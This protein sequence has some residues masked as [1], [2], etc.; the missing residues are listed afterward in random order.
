MSKIET[1][2][3]GCLAGMVLTM[4]IF[5]TH[6]A[7]RTQPRLNALR[8][9]LASAYSENRYDKAWTSYREA[10]AEADQLKAAALKASDEYIPHLPP[11]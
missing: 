2:M 7:L 11:E 9:E 5:F 4:A 8:A 1:F 10:Q 6:H 3:T